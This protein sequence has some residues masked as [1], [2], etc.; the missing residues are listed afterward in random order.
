MSGP[1]D[2]AVSVTARPRV[3]AVVPARL[4]AS[5][6]PNK[7]LAMILD[8]PMVEHVRRRAHLVDV[9]DDV[10]V[11]T[12][13]GAIFDV[14]TR[15]G[16]VAVM[17]ADTH[18]RCTER[19]AEA[20]VGLTVDI[21][22]I[23]QGDEP[24]LRPEAVTAAVRPL[25]ADQRITCTNLLS[26]LAAREDLVDPDIVKAACG[27]SG[28]ILF[29]TR[30]A[31]PHYR[32]DGDAPVYRQTGIWALRTETLRAFQAL[33]ET[34]LERIESIDMLRLLEHGYRIRG[35]VVS[36]S[37]VGVDRPDDVR[38]VEEILKDDADQWSLY[39]RTVALR[40]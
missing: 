3:V 5:R 39:Q 2:A 33:P 37:T 22:A 11:A 30:A 13:D 8:L 20:A 26:P 27:R 10:I 32:Q 38:V 9:V 14:V 25:L 15:A 1:G 29:L 16:G 21:V 40:P 34:P 24:L 6:F 19:V 12:C 7:P 18:E 23:V 31:I 35:V 28:D 4:A 17:T 36:Y